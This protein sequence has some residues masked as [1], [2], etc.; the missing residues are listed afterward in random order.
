MNFR[1]SMQNIMESCRKFKIIV[2]IFNLC[3]DV[4]NIDNNI[5]I[6]IDVVIDKI[7]IVIDRIA[8][9]ID[10]NNIDNCLCY[11]LNFLN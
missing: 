5:V 9:L 3:A 8:I 11:I 7:V 4:N 10:V 1:F 2:V 6:V